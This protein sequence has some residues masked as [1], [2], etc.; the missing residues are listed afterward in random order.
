MW[1]AHPFFITRVSDVQLKSCELGSDWN[2]STSALTRTQMTWT[3]HGR[4]HEDLKD[5][6]LKYIQGLK[7]G[8]TNK[9]S[10]SDDAP[11]LDELRNPMWSLL[12]VSSLCHSHLREDTPSVV[13]SDNGWPWPPDVS[14]VFFVSGGC[15][16]WNVLSKPYRHQ[17]LLEMSE[18][19]RYSHLLSWATVCCWRLFVHIRAT[20]V[21]KPPPPSTMS[22]S[23][24]SIH[25]IYLHV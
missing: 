6:S 14:F 16:V 15:R 25:F 7:L 21:P 11:A 24:I 17:H 10:F 13:V 23:L 4:E 2:H 3:S 12:S 1:P 20:N 9:L 5:L 8:N 19:T 22:P 18:W